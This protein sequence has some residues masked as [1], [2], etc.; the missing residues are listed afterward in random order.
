MVLCPQQSARHDCRQLPW[1]TRRRLQ[2]RLQED[3]APPPSD[4][5]GWVGGR[6]EGWVGWTGWTGGGR[7]LG[8]WRLGSLPLLLSQSSQQPQFKVRAGTTE[9]GSLSGPKCH[10]LAACFWAT[11]PLT[12]TLQ[13]YLIMMS[14]VHFLAKRFAPA[15]TAGIQRAE[16]GCEEHAGN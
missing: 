2:R 10:L 5:E 16:R 11:T 6:E 9:A 13:Q 14:A 1:E 7:G 8:G 3:T 4:E 15:F 12:L